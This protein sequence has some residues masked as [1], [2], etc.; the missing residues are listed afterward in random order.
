MIEL[1]RNNLEDFKVKSAP[2]LLKFFYEEYVGGIASRLADIGG[3]DDD[4]SN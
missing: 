3:Y 1:V 4:V 2:D